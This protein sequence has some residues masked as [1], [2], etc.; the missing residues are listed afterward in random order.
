LTGTGELHITVERSADPAAG[1][2]IVSSTAVLLPSTGSRVVEETLAVLLSR[3]PPDEIPVSTMSGA[4]PTSSSLREQSDAV[5]DVAARP[6]RS[7][8][9]DAGEA[10]RKPTVTVTEVAVPGPALVTVRA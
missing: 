8:S 2:R 3:P 6:S 9:R 10:G 4:A 5:R 7:P 1:A